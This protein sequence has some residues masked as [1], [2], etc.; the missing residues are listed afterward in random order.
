L[1]IPSRVICK[2]VAVLTIGS[3]GVDGDAEGSIG[4]DV[5]VGAAVTGDLVGGEVA[6]DKVVV[7]GG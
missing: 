1:I 6:G 7:V 3:I 4:A 2:P 5:F